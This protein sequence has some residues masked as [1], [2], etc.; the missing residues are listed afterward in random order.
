MVRGPGGSLL[1]VGK[2]ARPDVAG[3]CAM[4]MSWGSGNPKV[5]HVKLVNKT[6]AKLKKTSECYLRILPIPLENGMWVSVS[7]A[8]V[9]NDAGNV[10][11]RVRD[12]LC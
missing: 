6:I 3:A 8:I 4:S 10:S 1:W 11:G 2:K 12:R 5:Q 9:A 7:D